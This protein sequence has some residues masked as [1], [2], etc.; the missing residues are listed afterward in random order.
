MALRADNGAGRA[1]RRVEV[2]VPAQY[3]YRRKIRFNSQ[4]MFLTQE[5]MRPS[6]ESRH[7]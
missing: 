2:Q 1:A 6:R 7:S 3:R 4:A 5:R